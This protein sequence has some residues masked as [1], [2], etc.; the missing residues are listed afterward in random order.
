MGRKVMVVPSKV[1]CGS[2]FNGQA[3]TAASISA[4]LIFCCFIIA[5]MALA[6]TCRSA[7]KVSS[8]KRLRKTATNGR[9][10]C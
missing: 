4:K 5:A 1:G 2:K 8:V 7:F 9:R 10:R 3:Q 6:A